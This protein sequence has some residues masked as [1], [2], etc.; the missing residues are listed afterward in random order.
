MHVI[1]YPNRHYAPDTESLALAGAVIESLGELASAIGA[2]RASS[3]GAESGVS[4]GLSS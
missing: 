3:R 4:E 1:A 2:A